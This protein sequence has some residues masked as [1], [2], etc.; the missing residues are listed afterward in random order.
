MLKHI[1]GFDQFQG[2]GSQSLL[3]SLQS[4]GYSVTTGMGI[5]DGRKA[6][7][8]ALELQMSPGAAGTS[9]SA[10]VNNIKSNLNAVAANSQ[11]RFVAV[12]D[13]GNSTTSTDGINWAA[14]VLGVNVSMRGIECHGDTYIAVG[15]GGTIL[16]STD[17]QNWSKRSAPNGAVNLVDVAYGAG[18][19][20]AVG[21]LGG[22]GAIIESD[23]DGVTWATV[24][25]NPGQYPNL[26]VEYGDA[27]LVGGQYGQVLTSPNGLGFTNRAFGVVNDVRD[28]AFFNGTW[29]A[30]CGQDI[31]RSV[32][33]GVTWTYAGSALENN[34]GLR[35]IDV[36]DG[37]WVVGGDRGGLFYSDDTTNWHW[38]DFAEIGGQQ[39][40]YDINVSTGTRVGW[41]LVG[42]R[43]GNQTNSTAMVYVS[44]AP[45]TKV[46][47]TLHSTSNKV[48]IGFAHRA[49]ARGKILSIAGLFDLDWPAGIRIL[50][51]NGASVP[52]R[53]TWYYYEI[54]IDKQ[55]NKV[56]LHVNDTFDLEAPLP[57]AAAAMVDYTMTWIAENG[58]VARL[59]DLYL[60]D[61]DINGGAS[62]LT[63]RLK[64]I[65]VSLRLPT[66]DVLGEWDTS[67]P[68]LHYPL[69]GL[70][71]PS[72]DSYVRSA[73]SGEQDLYSS[74]TP[75]PA[76]A[77]T[78]AAPII[79]LGVLALAQK[80]DLDNRQLGLV[81][82]APGNQAEV[83]D[84]VLSTSM[85]Y[86]QALFEKTPDGQAWTADNVQST[87]FGIAVRP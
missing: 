31:R 61:G 44:M 66:A 56:T 79:A 58:A 73:T 10:R 9:W 50:G 25:E 22:A 71:P 4:A 30:V 41:C 81:I 62:A 19:W 53:N 47:R 7:T 3:S 45:P 38:C 78:A 1:D 21:S 55:A 64:P 65:S 69:V 74:N 77:G 23:D 40:V 39:P 11:G 18:R 14:M 86:S 8:Y 75:L 51:V 43:N 20:L 85:E 24:T 63:S 87:P 84:T 16:R 35:C 60:L 59:D 6:A 26:C 5:A 57:A 32:D 36:S 27:W 68:G 67:D 80:S 72:T 33:A 37:R 48:V 52:I 2:Q 28:V 46:T 17:G 12:G 15:D 29:L 13:G 42:A 82:G 49:T 34:Y 83:V 54:T 70:L 76:G